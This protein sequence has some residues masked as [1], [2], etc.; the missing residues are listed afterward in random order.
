MPR[1]LM[2]VHASASEI[3]LFFEVELDLNLEV[4][5]LPTFQSSDYGTRWCFPALQTKRQ[6]LQ[7]VVLHRDARAD[8]N[9]E[10]VSRLHQSEIGATI[11]EGET[12]GSTGLCFRQCE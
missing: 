8:Q 10:I 6:S 7:P 4:G 12:R 11:G 2:H 5:S 9:K 1:Q 3:S